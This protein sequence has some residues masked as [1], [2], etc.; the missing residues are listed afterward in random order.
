MSTGPNILLFEKRQRIC[1][2]L[3]LKNVFLYCL[4]TKLLTDTTDP[5]RKR[6]FAKVW[7]SVYDNTMSDEQVRKLAAQHNS[8]N[9]GSRETK[10]VE[11]V[12]TC[13]EWLFRLAG[14]NAEDDTPNVSTEWKQSCQRMYTPQGK[15][16]EIVLFFIK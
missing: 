14:K 4:P 10:W 16:S 7:V 2:C 11:R 1:I 3:L 12:Q 9:F 13:R 5:S 8:Q 6:L 15:V